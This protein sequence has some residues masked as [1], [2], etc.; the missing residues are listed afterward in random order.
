MH[1]PVTG[2]RRLPGLLLA[3]ALAGSMMGGGCSPT[4]G[5]PEAREV[6]APAKS[7][8]QKDQQEPGAWRRDYDQALAEATKHGKLVVIDFY[9]DWCGPCKQMERTT[10]KDDAVKKRLR[11]FIP[12]KV[13]TDEHPDVA[14]NYNITALPTTVVVQGSGK[15]IAAK[16]GYLGPRQFL[17]LLDRAA[18]DA[19]ETLG[20]AAPSRGET[21]ARGAS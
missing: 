7:A 13:N 14:A 4:E 10:F 21:P 5:G 3:A 15:P 2:S 1:D 8:G 11:D 6:S 19:G 17:E 20:H 18:S 9:A 16:V 12:L